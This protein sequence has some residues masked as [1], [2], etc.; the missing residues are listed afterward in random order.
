M[1][2]AEDLV[3]RLNGIVNCPPV[4][5]GMQIAIRPSNF[6]FQTKHPA[7]GAR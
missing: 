5:A 7:Q 2:L 4:G 1:E 3:Q 6:Q